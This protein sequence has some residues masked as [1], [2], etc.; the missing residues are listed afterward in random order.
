MRRGK[1]SRKYVCTH[2]CEPV[3]M[4]IERLTKNV[5]VFVTRRDFLLETMQYNDL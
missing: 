2:I 1:A 4:H 3:Y 5:F